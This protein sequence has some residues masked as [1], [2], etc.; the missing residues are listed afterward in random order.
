MD[1]VAEQV[2]REKLFVQV[3]AR[4]ERNGGFV[5]RAELEAVNVDGS[6]YRLIDQSRGIWNPRWMSSTLSI[7]SAPDGPYDDEET[8]GGLL[9]YAYRSGSTDGD[10]RKLRLA[11]ELGSPLLLLRKIATGVY[12][13]VFPVFV[14]ADRPDQGFFDIALDESVR[15]LTGH[16][17]LEPDHR[18]YA[19]Q[20]ARVRLHQAE[21]RG[22][23]I[24]AYQGRCAV[25]TLKHPELLDAA[26]ILPDSHRLGL[27]VVPNGLALCK[28]HHAAYDQNLMGIDPDTR[29]H[30]SPA[31]LAESDGPMLRH[32]LQE[33]DGRRL[34]LPRATTERPDRD[35]LQ[36]R[37]EEFQTTV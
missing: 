6:T 19:E 30:L 17:E 13:P 2:L 9:H 25:C 33:M 10:N 34:T 26:H 22:K 4:S 32:G 1:S 28:I 37:F 18:R 3:G 31:V 14:V 5:T 7:L 11:L 24:R 8:A 20:R 16:G 29:V 36:V 15:L 35:R 27:P 23:V 21:F 12:V